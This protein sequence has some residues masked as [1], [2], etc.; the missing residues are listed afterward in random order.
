M[1]LQGLIH[2]RKLFKHVKQKEIW[3]KNI[4]LYKNTRA[5]NC[6]SVS[7]SWMCIRYFSATTILPIG[8]I[9]MLARATCN[10]ANNVITCLMSSKTSITECDFRSNSLPY[11]VLL[12]NKPGNQRKKHIETSSLLLLQLPHQLPPILQC[13]V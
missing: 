11:V 5:K 4:I 12:P 10:K 2:K 13:L 6:L 9:H 8:V 7:F 3:T 1:V